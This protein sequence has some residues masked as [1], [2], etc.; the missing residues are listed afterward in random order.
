[1]AGYTEAVLNLVPQQRRLFAL[2]DPGAS[3]VSADRV[4]NATGATRRRGEG[5]YVRDSRFPVLNATPK[6]MP[7]LR[8]TTNP[9][10]TAIPETAPILD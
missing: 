1:V 4:T 8:P 3:Y 7:P 2:P 5:G 10:P 6:P 9:G